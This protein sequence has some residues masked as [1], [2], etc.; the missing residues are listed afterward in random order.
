ML[1]SKKLTKRLW[2]KAINTSCYT[3]NKI[4]IYP[5]TCKT[6]YRI[7]KGKKHNLSCFHVFGSVCYIVKNPK[8]LGKF[9]AKSDHVAFFGYSINSKAYCMYNMRTQTI[10]EFAHV[11]INES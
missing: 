3:I 11:V 1:N 4:Y 9:D 6:P 5:N 7:W 10:I 2:A 8:Q